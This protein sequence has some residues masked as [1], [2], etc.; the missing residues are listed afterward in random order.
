M[1]T[2]F[3]SNIAAKL[4]RL[5]YAYQKK[6]GAESITL[7]YPLTDEVAAGESIMFYSSDGVAVQVRFVDL[8]DVDSSLRKVTE[9]ISAGRCV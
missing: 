6:Y 7:L 2:F 1:A 3:E 8:F 5:L 4:K 9:T